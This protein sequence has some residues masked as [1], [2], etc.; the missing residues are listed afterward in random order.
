M[1]TT[2][3]KPYMTHDNL[4]YYGSFRVG[5]EKDFDTLFK[6]PQVPVVIS[7]PSGKFEEKYQHHS[8]SH[9]G[10]ITEDLIGWLSQ[11]G[12]GLYLEDR[13]SHLEFHSPP[14]R[15]YEM[16]SAGLPII[17]PAESGHTLRKA[18][19]AII[20]RHI[21]ELKAGVPKIMWQNIERKMDTRNV[22]AKEQHTA[23]F[24]KAVA[25]KEE[26]PLVMKRAWKKLEAAL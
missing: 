22:I 20:D 23:W 16:L 9:T 5:R 8:V 13:K 1:Q 4:V 21:F 17:F 12:L 14:N 11:H 26:L 10:A 3:V 2:P 24:N 18:G 25:E 6:D 19:Y 7:S 15:F